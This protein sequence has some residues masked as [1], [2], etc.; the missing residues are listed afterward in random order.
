MINILVTLNSTYLKPLKVMLQSL[1][2][3]NSH[4]T[5]K[6]FIMHTDIK[7]EEIH[8]LEQFVHRNGSELISV[9]V[10]DGHFQDAPVLMHYTKEMYY[11]L[12]A[13]KFLPKN[14]D[15]ILYLDP[16]ILVLNSV[17]DLY[18]MDLGNNLF[19]A[20]CHNKISVKG[21]N[22]IRLSPYE[23]DAYYN[24]GVLLMN[25]KEQRK[26]INEDEIFK[27]VEENKKKL[28]LPDQDILNALYSKYIKNL[29]ETIYNYDARYYNYYKLM[30][31][32][33]MDMDYVIHH[34]VFLHFCGKKK[35]WKQN[36]NGRF[37]ALYK[38]YDKMA[39]RGAYA[40]GQEIMQ[41]S[42]RSKPI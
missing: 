39:F 25:L 15:R 4:K 28:I 22:Q 41:P 19:A 37:H 23:I 20:A 38:H 29:E 12:L 10:D 5:F 13:F 26:V 30:S 2:L 42:L 40:I 34:T 27:F 32:H 24:S 1:F 8:S 9:Q 3:N 17:D 21:I 35:P 16:D 33:K 36:Y 6:I 18:E 7:T 14:L 11:R 31:N